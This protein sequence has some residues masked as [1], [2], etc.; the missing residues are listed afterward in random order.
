MTEGDE[1]RVLSQEDI[2]ALVSAAASGGPEPQ[3]AA[4]AP[5]PPSPSG[6]PQASPPPA[7]AG[8][9]AEIVRRLERLEEALSGPGGAGSN[10][11]R[12]QA[13]I[14]TFG[15]DLQ[16]LNQRLDALTRHLAATLGYRLRESF[17]CRSCGAQGQVAAR[18]KCTYCDK[19]IWWGW[20]PKE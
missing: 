10:L 1:N 13:Y 2:D 16:A 12:L 14:D 17:R 19:E 8:D 20:W 7:P 11:R 15:R 9:L 5:P 3:P 4:P 6:T 18:V